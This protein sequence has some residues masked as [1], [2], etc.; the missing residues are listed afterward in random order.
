MRSAPKDARDW[1]ENYTA[2]IARDHIELQASDSNSEASP[3]SVPMSPQINISFSLRFL[4]A[5]SAEVQ[6]HPAPSTDDAEHAP[7]DMEQRVA[8]RVIPTST[9]SISSGLSRYLPI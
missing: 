6:S 2:G 8:Y 7:D 4:R 5:Y 3:F 1:L 9:S